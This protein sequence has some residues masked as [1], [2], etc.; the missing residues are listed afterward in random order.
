MNAS[1]R[2]AR[3]SLNRIPEHHVGHLGSTGFSLCAALFETKWGRQSLL[4]PAGRFSVAS[5]GSSRC[6][7]SHSPSRDP[8]SIGPALLTLMPT[9]C[10]SEDR[11]SRCQVRPARIRKRR[12]ADGSPDAAGKSAQ[13]THSQKPVRKGLQAMV[14]RTIRPDAPHYP[15]RHAALP[16]PVASGVLFAIW[17]A[18]RPALPSTTVL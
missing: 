18:L 12:S 8:K 4:W 11:A 7:P 16:A 1:T 14:V 10:S 6:H 17:R 15:P 9:L 13:T 3:S 2:C 5:A